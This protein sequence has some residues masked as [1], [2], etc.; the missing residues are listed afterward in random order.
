MKLIKIV[1]LFLITLAVTAMLASAAGVSQRY[2]ENPQEV[3]DVAVAEIN[4][5]FGTDF[6]VTIKPERMYDSTVEELKHLI[7]SLELLAME[8]IGQRVQGAI[9][10]AELE[11]RAELM[12]EKTE[13]D[14]EYYSFGPF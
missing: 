6:N 7:T 12:T 2:V 11:A 4:A 9:I 14:L 8:I 10:L 3:I 13:N 1:A 5:I